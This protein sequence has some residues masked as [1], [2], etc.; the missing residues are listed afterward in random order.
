MFGE[1]RDRDVSPLWHAA[2]VLI[3]ALILSVSDILADNL[4]WLADGKWYG[5][6]V[7]GASM[8]YQIDFLE[9]YAN[10]E[11]P[12]LLIVSKKREAAGYCHKDAFDIGR[13]DYF[14]ID[15]L[16]LKHPVRPRAIIA[17]CVL[18]AMAAAM[19]TAVIGVKVTM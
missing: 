9:C 8:Y 19:F 6:G 16:N 13:A 15:D 2:I 10:P 3:V 7:L 12:R 17:S 18:F 11:S 4:M 5:S 1:W 14:L